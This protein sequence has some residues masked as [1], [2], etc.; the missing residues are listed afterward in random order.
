[1]KVRTWHGQ[2]GRIERRLYHDFRMSTTSPGGVRSTLEARA[3]TEPAWFQ[4]ESDR[5]F[6]RMSAVIAAHA[7]A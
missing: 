2:T 4:S 1:M 5:I 6:A 7:C 3:Y